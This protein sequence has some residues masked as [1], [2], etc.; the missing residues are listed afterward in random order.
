MWHNFHPQENKESKRLDVSKITILIEA[1]QYPVAAGSLHV[2]DNQELDICIFALDNIT[3]TLGMF[4]HVASYL[5]GSALQEIP[6]IKF[7][8]ADTVT[9]KATEIICVVGFP[10]EP[11]PLTRRFCI[12]FCADTDL[13]DTSTTT[14]STTQARKSAND[15]LFYY[16]STAKGASGSAVFNGEGKVVG[17][18]TVSPQE[19][20]LHLIFLVS[21]FFCTKRNKI[22]RQ[23]WKVSN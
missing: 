3:T 20:D 8:K 15:H 7:S 19:C 12:G 16:A 22:Y 2:I 13:S 10:S 14:S 21:L 11:K 9:Q 18:H 5:E 17:I 23:E 4:T 6:G 1:K